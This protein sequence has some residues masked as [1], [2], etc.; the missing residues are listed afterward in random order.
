MW[1]DGWKKKNR[2]LPEPKSE[3]QRGR[4]QWEHA[5]LI[6]GLIH[7][8][9]S[10]KV[11]QFGVL[12]RT[13]R[14]IGNAGRVEPF[15]LPEWIEW[16]F[17]SQHFSKR[18]TARQERRFCHFSC[19]SALNR[20]RVAAFRWRRRLMV[21]GGRAGPQTDQIFKSAHH[22]SVKLKLFSKRIKKCNSDH[23]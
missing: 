5:P 6:K 15:P 2:F 21:Y 16:T 1:C 4:G 20:F 23:V 17:S 9:A 12:C 3:C 8:S 14:I 11:F 7:C 10:E 13:S 22:V 18:Q 19:F